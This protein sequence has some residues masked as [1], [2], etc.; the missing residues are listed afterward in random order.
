[1]AN[2][3][4][5]PFEPPAPKH[6]PADQQQHEQRRRAERQDHAESENICSG[7]TEKP[8]IRSKFRRIRL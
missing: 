2:S 4:N 6:E 7:T 3:V 1:M 5:T 8:V